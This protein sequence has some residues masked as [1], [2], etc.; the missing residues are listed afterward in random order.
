MFPLPKLNRN[1]TNPN[2]KINLLVS[3]TEVLKWSW[4]CQVALG[5][6]VADPWPVWAVLGHLACVQ[7]DQV[8]GQARKVRTFILKN[9]TL[10]GFQQVF[11]HVLVPSVWACG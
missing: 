1:L 9:A 7:S 2:G 3:L 11:H 6:L 5:V 10:S 4:S 8:A